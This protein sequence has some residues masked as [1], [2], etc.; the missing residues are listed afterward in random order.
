MRILFVVQRYGERVSGGA[1]HLTR[2]LARRLVTRGH[3]VSVLTS[4]ALSHSDWSSAFA[5]GAAIDD[6]VEVH[7]LA[8]AAPRDNRL[9]GALTQRVTAP[10][11][12]PASAVLSDAW[13]A[14]LGPDLPDLVP[15]LERM[16]PEVDVTVFSGY[17]FSTSVVGLPAAAPH[18][19]V[20]LQPVVHDEPYVRLP[21]TRTLFDH[22]DAVCALTE[23]EAHL[24]RGRFRPS[25]PVEVVGAGVE[26]EA[27]NPGLGRTVRDRYG[28]GDDDF[29]I[30]V[31]RIEP[32]KGSLDLV[33]MFLEYRRRSNAP[34]RLVLVGAGS[35]LLPVDD[36]LV[37]TGFVDE[38]EKAALLRE[39]V[40]LVQP[41]YFES[42]SISLV[43]GWLAGL[44]ALVQ[45]WCA[46]LD[47]QVRRSGGGL[48][49]GDFS[50]FAASLD[51][52]LGDAALRR[53]MAH[54]GAVYAEQ[55][56]WPPVLDRFERLLGRAVEHRRNRSG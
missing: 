54:N 44:P 53:L 40:A 42:F 14:S 3:E 9:F 21:S 36:H 18:G 55:Y 37:V 38:S 12:G 15:S 16:V 29:L 32:G 52:L 27:R 41:S 49:Y 28:I 23:E 6:G 20:V 2:Q 43:E 47:G 56:A 51:V 7:R 5:P 25:G 22:A 30:C 8:V 17:L 35:S 46:V 34:V 1:E 24:I 19:P 50:E 11:T 26:L 31:G 45:R 4:T 10:S 39:A 48:S 13:A 33:E